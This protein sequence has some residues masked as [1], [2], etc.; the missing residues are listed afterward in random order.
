MVKFLI[1][2]PH[3]SSFILE[4]CIRGSAF[5]IQEIQEFYWSH[6]YTRNAVKCKSGSA[7]RDSVW[8]SNHACSLILA[9]QPACS[10]ILL[11]QL[12]AC[13]HHWLWNYA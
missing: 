4:F 1:Y 12:R 13:Q 11:V 10:K 3:R 7:C 5:K 9:T 8:R 6:T 2:F